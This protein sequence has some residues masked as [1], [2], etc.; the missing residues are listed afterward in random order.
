MYDKAMSL[1]E[2]AWEGRKQKLGDKH[3]DALET[4]N[5]LAV[6]YKEQ[7]QYEEAEPLLIEDLNGYRLKLGDS[8]PHTIE[9]WQDLIN[10]YEAWGK[11][12]KAEEWWAKL[13][14]TEAVEQ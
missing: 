7:A 2:E 11:L 3:P 5:D 10:L 9:S 13:P 8:H 14:Q 4:I 1:F 6:L 12:E